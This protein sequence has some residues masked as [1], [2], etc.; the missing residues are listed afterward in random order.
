M[1][2]FSSSIQE[3]IRMHRFIDE[4][5]DN[6]TE[7]KKAKH[8]LYPHYGKY[9]AVII[10]MYYDHIL[11]RNWSV[12]SPLNLDSFTTAAYKMLHSRRSIMPER[13][14]ATL[15]HMSTH[16]WLSGYAQMGG[17]QRAF[18]GLSRRARFDSKMEN[19]TLH[20]E[21]D[22][23]KLKEEFKRYMPELMQELQVQFGPY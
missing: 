3:G 13:S 22:Y 21:E 9:A 4:F 23:E 11:A 16:D 20:L 8:R 15:D 1:L 18:I 2:Q 14:L 5:M 12:F 6:H 10:D 19:A 7:V 17:M